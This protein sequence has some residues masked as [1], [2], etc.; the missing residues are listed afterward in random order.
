M[1][2]KLIA[3]GASIMIA[4]GALTGCSDSESNPSN[5]TIKRSYSGSYEASS[6]NTSDVSSSSAGHSSASNSASSGNTQTPEQTPTLTE[7]PIPNCEYYDNANYSDYYTNNNSAIDG[8]WQNY[9]IGD[10]YIM[11]WNGVYYMYVSTENYSNGVIAWKSTDLVNWTQ[12]QGEGLSLGYVCEDER[13]GRCAYAPEVFYYDGTFYMYTSPRGDGH[14]ILSSQS[15]EGP[16]TLV[17]DTNYQMRI[18]G[19]VFMDDDEKMYFLHAEHGGIKI[20]QMNSPIEFGSSMGLSNSSVGGWTEGPG[21]F[22]RD[23][24]Y[25]L[26]YTGSNVVSDAYKVYYS[27]SEIGPS[28]HTSWKLG[29]NTTLLMK[30]KTEKDEVNPSSMGVGHSSTVIG[31]D[32]DSHYIA[33]HILNTANGPNRSLAIDRMIFNGSQISSSVVDIGSVTPTLPEFYMTNSSVGADGCSLTNTNGKILSNKST[34][35]CFSAEFNYTGD[36]VS[37]IVSYS[38]DSNYIYANV[39][40]SQKKITLNKVTD[41]GTSQIA[42]STLTN[43]YSANSLHTVK[44]AYSNGKM[45]LYFDNMCKIDNATVQA[46]G[47]KIGYENAVEIY[48]TVFSNVAMGESDK[49]EVKQA[50]NN[51]GS[52][53]Y[54]DEYSS[55]NNSTLSEVTPSISGKLYD[56]ALKL[57]LAKEDRATYKLNFNQSGKYGLVMTYNC[58]SIGKRILI[59]IDNES[60]NFT[61]P[62]IDTDATGFTYFTSLIGNIN[63]A[64]GAKRIA[65]QSLDGEIEFISF[66]FEKLHNQAYSIN[67]SLSTLLQQE[68]YV[69]EWEI[70]NDNQTQVHKPTNESKNLLYFGDKGF[71][72]FTAEVKIKIPQ[73]SG[74]AGFLVRAKNYTSFNADPYNFVQGYFISL[75]RTS[76]GVNINLDKLDYAI[77]SLYGVGYNSINLPENDYLTL[78]VEAIGNIINVYVNGE[79][80]IFY[81]DTE[82]FTSGRIGLYSTSNTA[83]FKDISIEEN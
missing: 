4:T 11:R 36:N 47:G 69:T 35:N 71:T 72:N 73:D 20:V 74:K 25:Y 68:N 18:D 5:S 39:N 23:G 67:N 29:D 49:L 30:T 32:L 6:I 61:L 64:G 7:L 52:S 63:T 53:V 70:Y 79:W 10:P 21:I 2:K 9:G 82:P 33:Y 15:P 38:S 3:I 56:R 24:I 1:K 62:N 81:G 40:L 65:I 26:T 42:E 76:Y 55:L 13:I 12:C 46:S 58:N 48:S 34:S 54:E 80:L 75:E 83:L 43:T 59:K 17:N 44:I 16:F 60:Y 22:K 77:N 66:R 28:N 37:F 78:K 14:Y 8:Q 50:Q 31:P 51:I 45:D 27:T 41:S 57:T 19:S